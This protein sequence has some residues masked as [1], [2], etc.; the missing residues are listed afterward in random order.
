M[1]EPGR[2][3]LGGERGRV[4]PV[5]RAKQQADRSFAHLLQRLRPTIVDVEFWALI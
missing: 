1:P 3:G 5:G 2:Q 4:G